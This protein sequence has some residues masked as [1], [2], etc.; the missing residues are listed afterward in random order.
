MSKPI[1]FISD[2]HL[3]DSRRDITAS[4]LS[5][6]HKHSGECECLYILGDLFEVW[7]G[8][9]ESTPLTQT[10]ADALIS[11]SR[12]GSQ[13]RI[14]HGNR[15]FL[16]GKDYA[17]QCGAS[18]ITDPYILKGPAGDIVL[19]HGDTLCTDDTAYMQ[20]R[21]MVRTPT[22]QEAFL[23]QSLDARREF[24]RQARAESQKATSDKQSEI[25]DVNG[26]AV[27]NTLNT[28]QKA[29]LLHGH[30]HRPQIHDVEIS[31]DHSDI[32]TARRIVLGDWDK[33][34]WYAELTANDLKL[35]EFPLSEA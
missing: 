8:D 15:D 18:L 32:Q 6:L 17:Q 23:S 25:M 27:I 16:I 11:F 14:M 3:E 5:F 26:Q 34:G 2:L 29:T 1:L 10:V 24:A 31:P 22:W 20:F 9:D 4:L 7:I 30:T 13:I 19:M 28:H 12:Q 33:S 21:E 35:H